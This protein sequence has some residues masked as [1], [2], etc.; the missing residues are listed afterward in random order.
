VSEVFEMLVYIRL[1][2]VCPN[3]DDPIDAHK[4]GLAMKDR[5]KFE[6]LAESSARKFAKDSV[7]D[8]MAQLE[9][10]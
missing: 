8:W 5:K 10:K 3:Y 4:K 9:A 6:R 2:L 7:D 1:L